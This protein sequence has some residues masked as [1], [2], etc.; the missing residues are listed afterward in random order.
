MGDNSLLLN[1]KRLERHRR[2]RSFYVKG[3]CSFLNN[4][5]STEGYSYV[6]RKEEY[7]K[8][9]KKNSLLKRVSALFLVLA[10][11]ATT[12]PN[13]GL[14]ADEVSNTETS[15][16]IQNEE[17]TTPA[18]PAEVE[19]TDVSKKD[20][21]DGSE[22]TNQEEQPVEEVIVDPVELK[23]L[24]AK[25]GSN[26]YLE[27]ETDSGK[28]KITNTGGK[29]LKTNQDGFQEDISAQV[30]ENGYYPIMSIELNAT[31][32]MT[33]R[34]D[35][36]FKIEYYRH[37]IDNGEEDYEVTKS[38][39]LLFSNDI[40]MDDDKYLSASFTEYKTENDD[41]V[42]ADQPKED[43]TSKEEI[44]KVLKEI[45]ENEIEEQEVPEEPKYYQK[46]EDGTWDYSTFPVVEEDPDE[47]TIILGPDGVEYPV[48]YLSSKQEFLGIPKS[49]SIRKA[50]LRSAP[51]YTQEVVT[52]S[53][54]NGGNPNTT[55]GGITYYGAGSNGK[56][57]SCITGLEKFPTGK[58]AVQENIPG[59]Q[60][61]LSQ[62]YL[63]AMFLTNPD[64]MGN[65]TLQVAPGIAYTPDTSGW[66]SC[67][68]NPPTSGCDWFML[69]HSVGSRIR[70]GD[71]RYNPVGTDEFNQQIA[72][73]IAWLDAWV[74]LNEDI[75]NGSTLHLVSYGGAYQTLACAS[76]NESTKFSFVKTTSDNSSADKSG[77]RVDVYTSKEDAKAAN[78]KAR[79]ATK[80]ADKPKADT[81]YEGS[82]AW[83]V[84]KSDG[85]MDDDKSNISALK[86][87]KT[88]YIVETAPPNGYSI[89]STVFKETMS[90][91][92]PISI[93]LDDVS[94]DP[95]G[96]RIYKKSVNGAVN[97]PGAIFKVNYYPNGRNP[98]NGNL[99]TKTNTWY[100][101]TKSEGSVK[102][103]DMETSDFK[104]G[105]TDC[106]PDAKPSRFKSGI[107]R[108]QE[109]YSPDG[110]KTVSGWL[111]I[112]ATEVNGSL[113]WTVDTNRST[114]A[115]KGSIGNTAILEADAEEGYVT[116]ND[117]VE[118]YGFKIGKI[119]LQ[120]FDNTDLSDDT[121]YAYSNYFG[122]TQG[123][124]S[125]RKIK[126]N[127]YNWS[128][129]GNDSSV[130]EKRSTLHGKH[131]IVY[132]K[133]NT[134]KVVDSG[135]LVCTLY[136]D[137]E[138]GYVDSGLTLSEGYYKIVEDADQ[139]DSYKSPPDE[140]GGNVKYCS[141]NANSVDATNYYKTYVVD[142]DDEVL[143][144][145]DGYFFKNGEQV[146]NN[147]KAWMWIEPLIGGDVVILKVDEQMKNAIKDDGS[148]LTGMT[149]TDFTSLLYSN[150][151]GMSY[152]EACG[153]L[154][155]L[156]NTTFRIRNDNDNVVGTTFKPGEDR[157]WR[158]A[159]KGSTIYNRW[160]AQIF[161]VDYLRSKYK[162]SVKHFNDEA[163]N[164]NVNGL[165]LDGNGEVFSMDWHD[166]DEHTCSSSCKYVCAVIFANEIQ[167]CAELQSSGGFETIGSL[168]EG[169][170]IVEEV[171]SGDGYEIVQEQY[172]IT[173]KPATTTLVGLSGEG[174]V[175]N[176]PLTGGVKVRKVLEG[177]EDAPETA[178]GDASLK[179]AEIS[180]Y[181]DGDGS[182]DGFRINT[183]TKK[184]VKAG[185]VVYRMYTNAR[186]IFY[187]QGIFQ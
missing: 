17:G 51:T 138:T 75:I 99:T 186:G 149:G 129:R 105:N 8:N 134:K 119:D 164:T 165:V 182:S 64:S 159:H 37:L 89:A 36:G 48:K 155:S 41:M 42:V 16:E 88:Y 178:P 71:F 52:M 58:T 122:K 14:W 47:G 59:S 6:K 32:R 120:F 177:Y 174:F 167:N 115:Y 81:A 150:N 124:A 157:V 102:L 74:G 103:S 110:F 53:K 20:Q 79:T 33:V 185:E 50:M 156:Q 131:T 141:L 78:K 163:D 70:Y 98:E 166:N 35:D 92:D 95:Y 148:S 111:E 12:L 10:T 25:V 40:T 57:Y 130:N 96:V 5:Y 61:D 65:G 114:G 30:T 161:C 77:C 121:K 162:K 172:P 80:T 82:I 145:G 97:I 94:G 26:G 113:V 153:Q 180:I 69:Q 143:A 173:V 106:K 86:N 112:V 72:N 63:L 3:I 187:N 171:E 140:Y 67:F 128:G 11:I 93:T 62:K 127:V 175:T 109:I 21:K 125:Y 83:A 142:D 13:S 135:D 22:E 183:Q 66:T 31:V 7:M 136:V 49:V 56:T 54:G 27:A 4:V 168:P 38:S 181:W 2:W 55:G 85:T 45:E 29:V 18:E 169:D 91:G 107:Y 126:F 170:Y 46:N 118:Y 87:G 101:K 158:F 147:K 108:F 1:I 44:E 19:Q 116:I 139:E 39:E 117:P 73:F 100:V 23:T 68:G 133:G 34:S 151:F 60:C 90:P 123:K 179:N 146:P 84:T 104:V 76:Y 15:Q 43:E 28:A 184:K 152:R 132:K 176:R 144:N 24:Y 154:N 160:E 9:S 137:P